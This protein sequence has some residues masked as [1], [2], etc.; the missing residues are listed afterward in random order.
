MKTLRI[1]SYAINGRGMGHLVRQLSI[2]RWV[3]R[4]T[5]VLGVQT[6]CWVLT[7]SEADTLARREGICAFKMPSKAMMRDA[8]LEPSRFMSVSRALTLN[9][10]SGLAPSLLIVDTFPGGSFGE[11]I[12]ALEMVPHRALVARKV[13]EE[14]E[15]NVAYRSL[16]PLYECIIEPDDRETGPIMIRE[17]EELL[18]RGQAREQLGVE[19]DKQVVYLTLGGGGDV[20]CAQVLPVTAP[21]LVD[22]GY[23][24]VV[25]AGPLYQGPEVRGPGITW[26]S[27]YVPMEL[28][29]GFDVAVSAGGY[30]SFH[31]L[32]Y[33]GVP[34][35]FTPQPRIS[36]DQEGRTLRAEQAG[37]GKRA[38]TIE[39][40]PDLVAELLADPRASEKARELVPENGAK[41][42]ALTVLSSLLPAE[43]LAMANKVLSPALWAAPNRRQIPVRDVLEVVRLLSG[44][45]P[46][47]I[48]R[49]R[50]LLGSL[51]E[52]GVDVASYETDLKQDDRVERFFEAVGKS[53]AP[54][55]H[56]FSLLK[57]LRRKFPAA[58]G[59]DLCSSVE[60][61]FASWSRF[62]DW[63][64][65]VSLLRAVPTQR[66]YDIN[67]FST[68][69]CDWLA[70][71]EDL[72]DAQRAFAHLERA[73]GRPVAEVLRM[74][75]RDQDAPEAQPSA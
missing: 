3:R 52:R 56:A 4:V 68:A 65:A 74:L 35:V 36:D 41:K 30:N 2:L 59:A 49:T 21:R 20:A 73:G 37:A 63:M 43:D 14:I 7:S 51:S 66:S 58:S 31:E 75:I 9:I 22:R 45:T 1:V 29:A 70:G 10:I 55:E 34:T 39:E 24:V 71:E 17:R 46:T 32:M 33:C 11:L 6:E 54:H 19:G 64:G 23:H 38:A 40:I 12:A 57:A 5:D 25:G 48:A 72:F 18:G 62:D 8:E 44:G 60:T 50:S 15:S 26:M 42:A 61:L 67:S 53:G 28:F 13:R 16:L 69:V 47:E 27:R